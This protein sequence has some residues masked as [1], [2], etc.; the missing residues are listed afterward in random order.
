M[1]AEPRE[2]PVVVILCGGRG[3]RLQQ[4]AREVPKP[5]VEIGGRPIVWHVIGIYAAQG[6]KRFV[7]AGGY[8]GE[9][10]ARFLAREHW[11]HGVS[12]ELLE[13]GDDTPTGGRVMR[14]AEHL[15][16]E[17][18][19]CVTYADGLADIDLQRLLGFHAAHGAAA[20]L[21]VVRPHLQFG[22]AELDGHDRVTGFAEK[23]RSEHWIN[24]GFFCFERPF[25]DSL[26]ADQVLERDPLEHLARAGQ[27]RAFRHEGFWRCMDTL[28]D[29][30]ALNDLWSSGEPP[31]RVWEGRAPGADA[32]AARGVRVA[33]DRRPARQKGPAQD[34]RVGHGAQDPRAATPPLVVP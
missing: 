12:V 21:T 27:L 23:P 5:L 33:Q 22:V 10:I 1:P 6:F 14:A 20:T 29:A 24:G 11:P 16:G 13:T 8:R 34:A 4:Q 30:I 18:R 2:R 9:Q 31:W 26:G 17:R 28:K 19:L 32:P 7:L 3:T 15:S 25:L